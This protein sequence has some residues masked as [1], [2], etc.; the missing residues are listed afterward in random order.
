MRFVEKTQ[1]APRQALFEEAQKTLAVRMGE[2]TGR[3][4]AHVE[5]SLIKITRDRKEALR[6]EGPARPDDRQPT[7]A[8]RLRQRPA[9]ALDRAG[10]ID[11]AIARPAARR[12]LC[13]SR[14]AR[15]APRRA[16]TCL[17]RSRPQGSSP[18]PE[19]QF[20]VVFQPTQVKRI[21]SLFARPRR[22]E[23]NAV[24]KGRAELGRAARHLVTRNGS[25]SESPSA[26]A[27]R[28]RRGCRSSRAAPNGPP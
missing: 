1:P 4:S 14:P 17:P 6:L 28:N 9:A 19:A 8:Q 21:G 27:C 11:G 20:E 25:T 3:R 24:E 2:I 15:R 13:Q 12:P 23:A 10:M 5:R 7:R 26:A 16:S 22:I 18:E